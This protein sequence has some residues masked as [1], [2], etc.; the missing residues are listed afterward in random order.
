VKAVTRAVAR[1]N[2]TPRILNRD[3]FFSRRQN[4]SPLHTYTGG[5]EATPREAFRELPTSLRAD[6]RQESE[7]SSGDQKVTTP[8]LMSG[9]RKAKMDSNDQLRYG[10]I[11]GTP[12]SPSGPAQ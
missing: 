5:L 9:R 12:P 11:V 4:N 1:A 7:E 10:S 8:M 3:T 2:G 6:S